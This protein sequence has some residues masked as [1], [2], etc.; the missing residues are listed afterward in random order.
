MITRARMQN[1]IL[2]SL[3]FPVLSCMSLLGARARP[4][5]LGAGVFVVAEKKS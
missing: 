5:N 4:Q 1:K 3:A 2:Y